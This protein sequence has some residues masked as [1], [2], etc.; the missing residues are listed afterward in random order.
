MSVNK[1]I[2]E[3]LD[4]R[5]INIQVDI[6]K[7]IAFEITNK[8]YVPYFTENVLFHS[9]FV[10]SLREL[11]RMI[12][13]EE[14]DFKKEELFLFIMEQLITEYSDASSCNHFTRT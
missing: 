10:S 2:I 4:Y 3:H 1:L 6:M 14:K 9:D 12:M 13:Q 11:H 5:C 7:K 8:E